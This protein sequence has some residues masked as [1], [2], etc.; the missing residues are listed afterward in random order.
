[1]VLVFPPL[2]QLGG[3]PRSRAHRY[4]LTHRCRLRHKSLSRRLP[5]PPHRLMLHRLQW[6]LI[7]VLI[8]LPQLRLIQSLHKHQ[9]RP[10]GQL[11][12]PPQLLT[13]LLLQLPIHHPPQ[14]QRIL[15]LQYQRI[16]PLQYRRTLLLQYQRILLPQFR[17]TLLLRSRPRRLSHNPPT[18]PN[19]RIR[20]Y[21]NQ[22]LSLFV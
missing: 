7:Q 9:R 10:P 6:H 15:L 1:M 4:P 20:L 19:T 18:I 2:S 13:R 5:P 14:Y 17:Q 3:R 22:A 16:L 12:L 11:T 8:Q 21:L